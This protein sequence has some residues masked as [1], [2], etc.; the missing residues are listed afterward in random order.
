[1]PDAFPVAQYPLAWSELHALDGR[2][3]LVGHG[4]SRSYEARR[5]PPPRRTS[6]T[7][8]TS[9]MMGQCKFYDTAVIFGIGNRN[10]RRY[11]CSNNGKW[12]DG[13]VQRCFPRPDPSDHSAPVWLLT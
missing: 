10:E 2:I 13:H 3:L 4:C 1:M 7:A 8:S 5:Y 12:S 11:P 6:R 9:W